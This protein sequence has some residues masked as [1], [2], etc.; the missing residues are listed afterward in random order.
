[1]PPAIEASNRPTAIEPPPSMPPRAIR[2]VHRGAVVAVSGLPITTTVLAWLREQ[3]RLTGTK[4]GCNEG[5]CGACTV[6]VGEL[7]Q[8]R[9]RWRAVNACLM[10]LPMLD[11]KALRTVEDLG[12]GHPAAR[13]MRECH[14]SQCGFCT[15]GFVV[16]LAACHERHA[17]AGSRPTRRELADVLSGNLCRCTGYRPILDAGEAMAGLPFEPP[18]SAGS[19][20]NCLLAQSAISVQPASSVACGC[21]A[22]RRAS[23]G[24]VRGASKRS[25][26][27][28]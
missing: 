24:S 2:F 9:L 12:A 26:A 15:P 18:E 7:V 20:R 10:L 27:W 8:D 5:D 13:A 28:R 11:G 14:G 3:A 17:A 25:P 6:M 21:S 23:S 16:S 22:A 19:G 4:E 1:M